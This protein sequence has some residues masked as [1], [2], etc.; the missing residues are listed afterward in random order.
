[1]AGGK[2]P[3]PHIDAIAHQGVTFSNGYAGNATCAPSRAAIMTGRYATRFGFEFT[4]TPGAFEKL[5]ATFDYA[6]RH[7][8][9][10]A[11]HERDLPANA[12]DEAVPG[13]EIMI[14]RLLHERGYHTMFLGKWHLGGTMTSKPEAKGYDETL[15][16]LAGASLFAPKGDPAI[17]EARQDFDPIDKF[18]WAN[19]TFS[20]ENNG[21]HR[22]QPSEYMTDYLGDQAVAAI[23]ANRNRPF[24][25]YLTFNAVHTPFQALK[26]DYDALP[27]IADHRLR[28]Y[29]A[30]LR[31]LDRNVGHVMDALKREGIDDNTL[32]I[33]T[34]DN[35]GAYYV[36]LPDINKPYR[37]WK[38]TF[39][40]GGIHVPFFMRWPGKL[41]A[42]K[43]YANPVAHVD[44]FA[45]VAAVAGAALPTDRKIDGVNLIPFAT[46]ENAG[47]PHQTLF[48]RSGP[49]ATLLDGDWKLQVMDKPYSRLWLYDLKSDPYEKTN[50]VAANGGETGTLLKELRTISAEQVKPLWPSLALVPQAVDHPLS[51]PDSPND[52]VV[53]WAN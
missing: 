42:G 46:G 20:V 33:F 12:N 24:F 30:M 1:V 50:L 13:R 19:L 48:W 16:F 11:A 26:S 25:M 41:P 14:P 39:F 27:Q 51:Y 17:E 8:Y 43:T 34:S 7:G 10:D 38:A 40:E 6:G 53:Y 18:L 44:I 23:H 45:T 2:A 52:E 3:T 35:G 28:V 29:A 37:G 31:A 5:I 36:G 4:P 49:Y 9:Y 21:G 47:R 32:V 22:F 15:G